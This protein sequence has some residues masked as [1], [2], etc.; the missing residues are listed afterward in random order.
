MSI[1]WGGLAIK[2]L[3]L[4]LVADQEYERVSAS[5][6]GTANTLLEPNNFQSVALEV[7]QIL[8]PPA[9]SPAPIPP[10]A[11]PVAPPA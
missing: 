6:E 7:A 5:P 11:S 2:S 3:Q 4:A 1:N 10:A 9:I 8:A